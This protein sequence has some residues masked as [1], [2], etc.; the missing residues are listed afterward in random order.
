MYRINEVSRQVN[1]SQKRIREYE[2]EGF[3]NPDRE[4][5]TNNRIYS[6]FE[7]AQIKRIN[8]LLHERGFTL[9]CLRSLF[10]LAPCWNIFDCQDRK[11]CSAYGFP[12]VPCWTVRENH[13]VKCLGS[14]EKCVIYI[15]R[16]NT[17][18]AVL[19]RDSH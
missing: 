14:C 18:A 7:V 5:N 2:K 12:H 1:L 11:Q 8:Y 9:S 3:V 16:N 17:S 10:V 4:A 13:E 15:N 19:E 6:D